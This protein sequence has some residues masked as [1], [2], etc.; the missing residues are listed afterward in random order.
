MR[1]VF[2][3]INP[4]KVYSKNLGDG[5]CI[6]SR[7]PTVIHVAPH[8]QINYNCCNEPFAVSRYKNACTETCMA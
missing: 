8:D 2:D 5:A 3:L 1:L 4:A 7:I 6:S